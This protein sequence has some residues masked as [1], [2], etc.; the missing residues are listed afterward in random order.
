MP[1]GAVD[2][3]PCDE[4]PC[5]TWEK[6][7]ATYDRGVPPR[8]RHLMLAAAFYGLLLALVGLW[9]HRM[10]E[11]LDVGGSAP[12][13]WM[14]DHLGMT[15][16]QGYTL[17][18]F[19]ANVALFVPLGALAITLLPGM[20]WRWC[21]LLGLIVSAAVEIAQDLALPNRTASPRD[22]LANGIGV[23]LGSGIAVVASRWAS[24]PK[25]SLQ[26]AV[27]ASSLLGQAHDRQRPGLPLQTRPEL[28]LTWR[29]KLLSS[30]QTKR[31]A[32]LRGWSPFRCFS[33]CGGVNSSVVTTQNDQPRERL[34][35]SGAACC[36]AAEVARFELARGLNLNPLSRRAH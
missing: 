2:V 20:R 30:H 36:V 13:R 19:S 26:S 21:V 8:A 11:N 5:D 18:E 17:V 34:V 4:A 28:H 1:D 7:A 10:D 6:T 32:T 35:I 12:V 15:P 27:E 25:A 16:A 29:S 14:V 24:R 33:L 31:P 23:A 22:V 3:I 9:P